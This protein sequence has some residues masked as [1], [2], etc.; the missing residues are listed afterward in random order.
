ML[1]FRSGQLTQVLT[2]SSMAI[3]CSGGQHL[4]ENKELIPL[5]MVPT[6]A[7]QGFPCGSVR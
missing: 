5:F 6:F 1:G 4:K 7:P 3:V 2:V